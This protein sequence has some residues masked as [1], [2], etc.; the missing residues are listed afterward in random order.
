MHVSHRRP[1]AV[2]AAILAAAV[3]LTGCIPSIP[4]PPSPTTTSDPTTTQPPADASLDDYLTAATAE[5]GAAVGS[6]S[7]D[8]VAGGEG[9]AV[10]TSDS[11]IAVNGG[12]IEIVVES[13]VPFDT[14]LVGAG[15][16]TVGSATPTAWPGS[17]EIALGAATTSTSIVV[18]VSQA[19]PSTEFSV[20]VAVVGTDGT[21]SAV[22]ATNVSIVEVGTGDVQVSVSWN[23]DVD[24]D[25]YVVDPNGET[26]YYGATTSSSGGE[27]DLDS[28]PSC[29]IDGIRN[30]NVTWPLGEAPSGTY[31]VRL[32][33]YADCNIDQ[34]SWVVTV[35]AIGRT[36]RWEGVLEAPGRGG[37]ED[38]GILIARF[39]V[40]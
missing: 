6:A 30:E 15:S 29:Q 24:V 14:V 34:T 17:Y 27:L 18:T 25:L 9:G 28:N 39:D 40:P 22:D 7:G 33:L 11:A 32:N 38:E 12:S 10:Q 23:E 16:T 31:E 19:P 21:V 35:Q 37:G 13:D 2:A 20:V 5:G 4:Q 8:A 1:L 36:Y 26:I 3:A